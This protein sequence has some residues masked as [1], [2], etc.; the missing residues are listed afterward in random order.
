MSLYSVVSSFNLLALFFGVERTLK[1]LLKSTLTISAIRDSNIKYRLKLYKQDIT[2]ISFPSLLLQ[3]ITGS[4]EIKPVLN[5]QNAI[6][7]FFGDGYLD[8]SNGITFELWSDP[9][10]APFKLEVN[11]DIIA[12]LS[13]I[14]S[15]LRTAF[16]SI[17]YGVF[18]LALGEIDWTFIEAGDYVIYAGGITSLRNGLKKLLTFSY[19]SILIVVMF[20][21]QIVIRY[22]Y[23]S[24]ELRQLFVGKNDLAL[25]IFP[26]M[27]IV[28]AGLVNL[29]IHV[30]FG[31]VWI[32]SYYQRRLG[33]V[34]NSNLRRILLVLSFLSLFIVD[35][36][37]IFCILVLYTFLVC[38][39]S[40]KV[41]I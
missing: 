1:P 19:V 13:S 37:I 18:I 31:L 35:I 38:V 21:H 27:F 30:I 9:D 33:F 12:S 40:R 41:I 25:I 8:D 36:A 20:L 15:S 16:I 23:F 7:S 32:A 22:I 10:S 11:I 6:I 4:T 28:A 2:E 26:L 24:D 39:H 5:I 3:Y 29:L 34:M 14:V 17:C